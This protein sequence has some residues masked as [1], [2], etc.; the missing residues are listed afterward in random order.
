MQTARCLT[1]L[2]FTGNRFAV[3]IFFFWRCSCD[4]GVEVATAAWHPA[5]LWFFTF[6]EFLV[7]SIFT[8]VAAV[9]T[10]N[11][12]SAQGPGDYGF[13]PFGFYQPYGARYGNSIR[14]PPYF[15]TNPPVYYGAR[16]A[17]PYGISPFASPPLVTAGQ[18]YESRLRSQFKQ[19]QVPTPQPICNP[20]VSH[21]AS[22]KRVAPKLG[23]VR[24]NP[25][26]ESSELIAKK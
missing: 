14:T 6:R 7:A 15:T 22:V 26:I 16:H 17:R 24:T 25:F 13:L 20:C 21:S 10:S 23:I 1:N 19:P 8:C 9:L 2:Q 18:N 12:A 5:R 11:T 4:G 3:I